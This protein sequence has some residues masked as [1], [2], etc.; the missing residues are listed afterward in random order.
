MS[1]NLKRRLYIEDYARRVAGRWYTLTF[2]DSVESLETEIKASNHPDAEEFQICDAEGFPRGVIGTYTGHCE[3]WAWHEVLED[4]SNED[5]FYAFLEAFGPN[6]FDSAAHALEVFDRIGY[7]TADTEAE[8]AEQNAI[9]QG[10]IPENLS[11]D[12]LRT[13]IDW[14][15]YWDC[16]LQFS[17]KAESIDGKLYFFPANW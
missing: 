7:D 15:R 11:G 1:T 3:A 12:D 10:L 8:F 13:Y 6:Y 4:V 14:Q 2:F 17:F 5:A 9:S 16:T